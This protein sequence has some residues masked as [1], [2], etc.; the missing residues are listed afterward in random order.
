[1]VLNY[2]QHVFHEPDFPG[3]TDDYIQIIEKCIKR[4][5]IFRTMGEYYDEFNNNKK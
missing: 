4:N 2:H 5:A 3:Y 1:L